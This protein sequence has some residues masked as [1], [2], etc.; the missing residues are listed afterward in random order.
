MRYDFW[1]S[2]FWSSLN[3]GLVTAARHT[4][5]DAYEPTCAYAQVG[6]IKNGLMVYIPAE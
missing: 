1:S 6:S 5:S 2:D 3:F 4:E